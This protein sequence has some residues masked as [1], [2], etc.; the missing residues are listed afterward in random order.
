M[1]DATEAVEVLRQLRTAQDDLRKKVKR[2]R[3]LRD[4]EKAMWV[5]DIERRMQAIDVAIES[6]QV[7]G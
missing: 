6:L 3:L 2:K 5:V 1:M 7:K 4:S